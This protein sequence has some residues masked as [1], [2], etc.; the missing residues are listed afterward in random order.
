MATLV[1]AR[2]ALASQQTAQDWL[3][4]RKHTVIHAVPER[5]HLGFA[6][7]VGLQFPI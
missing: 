4:T 7:V 6:E 2:R 5:F 3:N 1:T